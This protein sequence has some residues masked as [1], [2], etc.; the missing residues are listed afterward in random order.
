M[1]GKTC[2]V[3]K[4]CDFIGYNLTHSYWLTSVDPI[5]PGNSDLWITFV[6]KISFTRVLS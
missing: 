3:S 6:K 4:Y 1:E 2:L 5:D